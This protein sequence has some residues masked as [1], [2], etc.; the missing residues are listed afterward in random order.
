MLQTVYCQKV[1]ETRSNF[2]LCY[3]QEGLMKEIDTKLRALAKENKQNGQK[4]QEYLI[5]NWPNI[6][7]SIYNMVM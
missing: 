7:Q 6:S 2:R 5:H 3:Q 1:A 4:V